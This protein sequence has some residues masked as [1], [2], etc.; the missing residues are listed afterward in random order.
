[1]F[2]VIALAGGALFLFVVP[3]SATIINVPGDS[4][5]IQGGINGANNGDTVLVQPG[6]YFENV[7]FNGHNIVLGSL[8]LTTDDTSYIS[9]TIIDGEN[10]EWV[11]TVTFASGEDS[12]AII[13]GFTIRNGYASTGG[14]IHCSNNSSSTISYNIISG[15]TGR[16]G[17]GGIYCSNSDPMIFNNFIV[18]NGAPGTEVGC[19]GGIYCENSNPT[20]SHNIVIGNIA[21]SGEFTGGYGGGIFCENSNPTIINSTISRNFA[22]SWGGGIYTVYTSYPIITN[23]IFWADSATVDGNEIAGDDASWPTITYCDIQNILWPGEGNIN[24]DPQFCDPDNNN[25]YLATSSCCVG[26]GEGGV[27]IGALGVGCE[28]FP[29]PTLSEWGS[30]ILLLL[31]LASGT[32]AVIRRRKAVTVEGR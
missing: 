6:T 24:C 4:A 27:D 29:V 25:F 19:G 12:T 3:L 17:G 32:I 13:T 10:I 9:S 22:T 7:N 26:A 30:I 21:G 8:F 15:N 18:G 20:I 2:R 1:M 28:A 11:S 5:T 23:T 31:L 16:S 14:G